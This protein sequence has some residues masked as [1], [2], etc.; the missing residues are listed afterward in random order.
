M[1][2]SFNFNLERCSVA[3][4]ENM[5]FCCIRCSRHYHGR[6]VAGESEERDDKLGNKYHC[7]T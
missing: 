5:E 3:S 2:P 7:Y 4:S 6:K 1:K